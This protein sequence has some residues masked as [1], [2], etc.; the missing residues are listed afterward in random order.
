MARIRAHKTNFSAGEVSPRFLGRGDL[1][2]YENGASKLRNVFIHP[3][4]SLSRRSGLRYVDR[5]R[6]AGRLLAF[7]FNTEQVYLLVFTDRHCDVYRGGVAVASFIS[8]WTATHLSQINWTQSADTLLVV[9]PDVPPK[10]I[11]R[12]NEFDWHVADWVFHEQDE[13]IQAPHYKFAGN[14]VTLDPSGV[15]G[16]ITLKASKAVFFDAHVGVRFRLQDK[17]VQITAVPGGGEP[18]ASATAHVKETLASA[19]PTIDWT[20]SAF[21][22]VHGWPVAVT[23]HQDRLVIGGSRDLPNRL[24]L[25]KSADLF[26]FDLGEGLDDEGIEFAILSDQVNAIRAVFS[27]RHLQVFTS[28]AEWMVTGDPLTPINIQLNR[29]TRIG[30]AVE[31]TIPPRDVDGATLFVPRTGTQLREFLYTDVEQAYQ[32]SDLAMLA[33]HLIDSPV[34]IDFDQT[35]RLCHVVMANGSMATLTIY[36]AEQVSAWTLQKTVGS[37]R[38]VA[39]IGDDTYVLVEREGGFFIE[40]FDKALNVDS[41]LTGTSQLPKT[42]WNGLGHLEGQTV[43]VLADGAVHADVVVEGGAITLNAPANTIQSGLGYTHVIEPLPPGLQN[44]GS[45]SQGSKMRPVS[46]TFR[47]QRTGSFHL[48]TGR[49]FVEIPFKR[50]GNSILDCPA[51]EFS[52]DKTVRAFGWRCDGTKPLWRIEQDTPLPFT[53]LSVAA[54]I[55]ING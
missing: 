23:F 7:E 16:T 43:K 18:Y 39:A 3:S 51:S 47:F 2:A 10:K 14:D 36:R 54:E 6:G 45:G 31:R 46:F 33:Q 52:G 50:F 1:R 22:S 40:I 24:W 37:F 41:G 28:G 27:G 8:P 53:L 11:N 29:Q 5:A 4:G 20:E 13:R 38:A 21:S 32:A 19:Q 12:T 15:S 35:A 25:S 55:S 17:E 48:D 34:D 9:H 30:L 49:G 42:V 44:V 26:N